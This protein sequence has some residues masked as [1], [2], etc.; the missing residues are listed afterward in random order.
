[1]AKRSPSFPRI[2]SLGRDY[3]GLNEYFSRLFC[4][5]G[6]VVEWIYRTSPKRLEVRI[7]GLL[8]SLCQ[9][10]LFRADT[11][12]SVTKRLHLGGFRISSTQRATHN[13]LSQAEHAIMPRR[14]MDR[15]LTKWSSG[16]SD[17]SLTWTGNAVEKS[18]RWMTD[19]SRCVSSG[20]SRLS[21]VQV[22]ATTKGFDWQP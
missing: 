14:S 19:L 15:G 21:C 16:L 3:L 9:R 4:R 17:W 8:V 7:Q 13:G 1:M 6:A 20:H 5:L 2:V 10:L 12:F 18:N 11:R 22:F